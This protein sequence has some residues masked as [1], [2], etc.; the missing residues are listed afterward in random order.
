MTISAMY[1]STSKRKEQKQK[2]GRQN[3]FAQ[4]L[5]DEREC[6][7]AENHLEG[8]TVGYARNGQV[9]IGQALPREYK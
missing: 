5:A 4:I 2:S 3:S 9:F 6:L 7:N 1:D 8:K